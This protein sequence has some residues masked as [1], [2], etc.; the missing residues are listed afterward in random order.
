VASPS[1][2]ELEPDSVVSPV[3]GQIAGKGGIGRVAVILSARKWSGNG[4]FRRPILAWNHFW[5]PINF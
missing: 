3:D 4:P 1:R 2:A 5:I